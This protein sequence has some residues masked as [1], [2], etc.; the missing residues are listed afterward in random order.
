MKEKAF[1]QYLTFEKRS[2]PHT[3]KAYQ[4][5]LGQFREF[6][7]SSLGIR[8]MNE[9]THFHIRSWMV[10]L[11]SGGF[12][13]RSINRKLSALKTYFNFLVRHELIANSP[14]KK[15]V[16][17]K[18]ERR[19]PVFVSTAEM[20]NLLAPHHFSDDFAGC[21]DRTI[22]L[23]FYQTGMR[24][25]ELIGL[26]DNDILWQDQL[27]RV[28]GKGQKERLVPIGPHL[29]KAM[30]RFQGVRKEIFP[31]PAVP[32]FF[33]TAK[34]KTLYPKLVY[35]IVSQYLSLLPSAD[36]RS[37]HV[38]RHTFA[39]HLLDNGADLNAT[40]EILG[41]ASLAATQIYTHN[42]IER[43]K[44]VY[45]QAHPKSGKTGTPDSFKK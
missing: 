12:A 43:L 14:L 31:E 22:L 33:V 9:V 29:Q 5:D 35:N 38:L 1:I 16:S 10:S 23:L 15:V 27:V 11:L 37:P 18:N 2:S 28:M 40:K 20:E 41:H 42:T 24:R 8:E 21:R 7:E 26:N 30:A 39:T 19:L 6:L 44:R 4:K 34:G 13:T 36:K 25:S 32:S 45:D 17:P 3:I